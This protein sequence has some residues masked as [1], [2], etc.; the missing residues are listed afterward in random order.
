MATT[1]KPFGNEVVAKLLSEGSDVAITKEVDSGALRTMKRMAQLA[2]RRLGLH[3][4][5]V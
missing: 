4:T 1:T 3:G 2:K 5:A